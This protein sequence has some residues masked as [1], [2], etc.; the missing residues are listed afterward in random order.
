MSREPAS[1]SKGTR[2]WLSPKE[3][4]GKI[5]EKATKPKGNVGSAG[6]AVA[7]TKVRL[8]PEVFL[9]SRI[10]ECLLGSAASTG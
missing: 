3:I 8:S 7:G 1:P 5:S 2:T 6:I 10:I 4:N 9:P